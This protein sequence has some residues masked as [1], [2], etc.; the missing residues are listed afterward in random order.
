MKVICVG[1]IVQKIRSNIVLALVFLF[2]ALGE[3]TI[4]I[5]QALVELITNTKYVKF[6]S[7]I[8][9]VEALSYS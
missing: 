1:G 7:V 9:S 6:D 4:C 5:L 3:V 2:F 8:G